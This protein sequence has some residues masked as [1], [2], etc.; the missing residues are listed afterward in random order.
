MTTIEYINTCVI[1]EKISS[2]TRSLKGWNMH[3]DNGQVIEVSE[4]EK[5]EIVQIINGLNK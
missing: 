3:L 1:V 4:D 2:F 5:A